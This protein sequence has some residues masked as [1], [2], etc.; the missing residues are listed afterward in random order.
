[1][2]EEIYAVR[3]LIR[4]SGIV[5][6]CQGL[7]QSLPS[8]IVCRILL[9]LFQTGIQ[10]GSIYLIAAYYPRY[11]LQARMACFLAC[12]LLAN[13]FGGVSAPRSTTAHAADF[14]QLLAYALVHM[15]GLAGYPAWR[16]LFI[17]EGALVAVSVTVA[18]FVPDWPEQVRFLQSGEKE[19]LLNSL[20]SE[21][22]TGN[23]TIF[24][25]AREVLRDP[26]TYFNAVIHFCCTAISSS[27]VVFL[28][29]I[30]NELGWHTTKALYMTIPVWIV[31][32]VVT[33]LNG[34]GSDYIK[35]RYPFLAGSL[36]AVIIAYSILLGAKHVAVGVRYMACFFLISGAFAADVSALT[37]LSNNVMGQKRRGVALGIV[38]AL[39]NLGYL[40]GPNVYL[41]REAPWYP[42]GFG[43]CLALGVLALCSA[44][45]QLVYLIRRSRHRQSD[46]HKMMS[47]GASSPTSWTDD[48]FSQKY[49][50]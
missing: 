5:T 46:V 47:P 43:V 36:V 37:W 40:V 27:A 48:G 10:G 41:D 32:F 14:P 49:M 19:T 15:E 6:I 7:T 34:I 39:G 35:R 21:L 38:G 28:P 29:T 4:I 12:R 13:A 20:K 30:L 25:L 22:H 26:K 8:L 23:C 2:K 42:T 24:T 33:V 16:W 50:F 1:M 31:A 17:I 9:G 3:L 11:A 44:T 45:T 18:L